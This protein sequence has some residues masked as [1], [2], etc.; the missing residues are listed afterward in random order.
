MNEKPTVIICVE[1]HMVDR[2][3]VDK[4]VNVSILT[5]DIQGLE[6]DLDLTESCIG[7]V[8]CYSSN[9]TPLEVNPKLAAQV[10]REFNPEK[11][12]AT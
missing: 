5:Y 8:Y 2:I 9:F 11:E 7:R 10:H 3:I 4:D 6:N 1:N 12:S